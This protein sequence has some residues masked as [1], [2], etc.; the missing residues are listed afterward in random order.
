[1]DFHLENDSYNCFEAHGNETLREN[2]VQ[3]LGSWELS[4]LI[5]QVGTRGQ[6]ASYPHY[7]ARV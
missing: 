1:M 7:S 4:A 2:Q 5:E 3:A 6:F